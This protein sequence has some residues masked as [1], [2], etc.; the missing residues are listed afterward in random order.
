M[1]KEFV[2]KLM[3]NEDELKQL[4][5]LHLGKSDK[6]EFFYRTIKKIVVDGEIKK[7]AFSGWAFFGGAFYFLYRKMYIY[8]LMFIA[9][10]FIPEML[11]LLNIEAINLEVV[12]NGVT[13]GIAVACGMTAMPTYINKFFDDAVKAG[14]G[15]KDFEDVKDEME[16]LGGYNI[17]AI[18]LY[19]AVMILL[20]LSVA[21]LVMTSGAF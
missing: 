2:K 1:K 8:G 19:F 10:A 9:A 11:S 5:G 6:V 4:L 20:I 13:M 18:Y 21:Y 16:K 17:W 12:E 7:S 14:Y 15:I 3:G